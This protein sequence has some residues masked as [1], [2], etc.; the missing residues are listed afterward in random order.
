MVLRLSLQLPEPPT[1]RAIEL[2]GPTS[3]GA[4]VVTTVQPRRGKK[5]GL[6]AHML[7]SPDAH[8]LRYR[9]VITD[10]ELL[11][12][13]DRLPVV[14]S[15]SKPANR[16]MVDGLAV[17]QKHFVSRYIRLEQR[18]IHGLSTARSY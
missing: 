17:S 15:V 8:L 9:L 6:P 14:N 11:L 16:W 13:L 18:V 12:E 10:P 7:A 4:W 5:S 3:V 2:D 1:Q